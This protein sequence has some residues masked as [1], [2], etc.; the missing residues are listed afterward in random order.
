MGR[1]YRMYKDL[2]IKNVFL[3]GLFGLLGGIVGL[4]P[5]A[6]SAW[7]F[8]NYLYWGWVAWVDWRDEGMTT[9][10]LRILTA[11]SP[12]LAGLAAATLFVLVN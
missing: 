2:T 9:N 6:V 1:L 8:I 11:T 5:W 10:E 12:T 4:S 7:I 3:G